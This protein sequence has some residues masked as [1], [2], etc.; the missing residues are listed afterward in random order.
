MLLPH[1]APG[2]FH[3]HRSLEKQ[4]TSVTFGRRG[5]RAWKVSQLE[6]E[7]GKTLQ[8]AESKKERDFP[9]RRAFFFGDL[10]P[11]FKKN[12]SKLCH[13]LLLSLCLSLFISP[14]TD[15]SCLMN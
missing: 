1:L 4:Q 9:S 8:P 11:K 15:N 12:K 13:H 14:H 2:A 5:V 7:L 3:S 6:K 10:L